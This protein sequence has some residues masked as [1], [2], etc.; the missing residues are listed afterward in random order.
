MVDQTMQ[1]QSTSIEQ[2]AE[3]AR[4]L[5]EVVAVEDELTHDQIAQRARAV[6]IRA[7]LFDEEEYDLEEYEALLEMY[8][9]TLTNIEEGEIVKAKVLRVT[10]KSVILDVGFKSEGSVNRDEFK[11]PDALQPGDEVEVYLENLEDE[12]GVVVLSKKKADFLRVWEKIRE[13]YENGSPVP[14]MLTRKI[15]GGVTVDLMGVDAFLPGSQI[16]LRRV[17][18]IEDLIGETYEFK[19]IK[20]NKRRRNIVVSRRVLLEAEREIK[21]EKL[22]KELEVGQVRRGVV[23]NITDFGA[24]IDLGGMDG[25]LHITDMSWGRVGHPARW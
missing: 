16:A 2:I 4:S 25:L 20:L 6:N 23:K 7:D 17:P 5:G 22:K 12:D 8:E 1:E 9:D 18:N 14:G 21:R 24:F 13:A 10:D 19:I 3:A 15:K 11:D